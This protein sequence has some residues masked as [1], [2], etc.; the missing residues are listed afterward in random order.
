MKARTCSH[1]TACRNLWWMQTKANER[2]IILPWNLSFEFVTSASVSTGFVVNSHWTCC[3]GWNWRSP[4]K[5]LDLGLFQSY[6]FWRSGLQ[7][8]NKVVWFRN[9]VVVLVF[10]Y[11]SY[12]Q[13]QHVGENTFCGPW[14]TWQVKVKRFQMLLILR[15]KLKSC[16]TLCRPFI[17][18]ELAAEITQQYKIV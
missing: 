9:Y 3:P 11:S 5:G 7:H 2:S 1:H 18:N 15:F 16:L 13:S 17:G 6:R 8:T 14:Q 4:N 10:F 12:C